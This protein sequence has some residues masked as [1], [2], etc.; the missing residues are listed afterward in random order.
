LEFKISQKK[1]SVGL[2]YEIKKFFGC[3]RIN[4]DN[5]KTDTMKFVI[6][7]IDDLM[8][9][10]IPHFD[11]YT[12]KTSKCLNYLDFK[13]AVFIMN[14]K[15]HYNI[16]GINN[17]KKIKSNMNKARSFKDKFDYC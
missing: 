7:N 9:K 8:N 6:T 3:G 5:N 10:V 16:E 17:L 1:H 2:L 14:E 13:K 4:V 12:L 11:E 15:E